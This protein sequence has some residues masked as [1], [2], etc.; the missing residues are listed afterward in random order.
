M[1]LVNV[2]MGGRAQRTIVDD[3]EMDGKTPEAVAVG[4]SVRRSTQKLGSQV[5]KW[6]AGA[7]REST[8]F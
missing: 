5:R 3:L 2:G 4:I 1:D 8:K 6:K 7:R